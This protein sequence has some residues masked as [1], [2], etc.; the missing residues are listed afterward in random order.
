[1][2]DPSKSRRR[3]AGQASLAIA[4]AAAGLASVI[5]WSDRPV[6]GGAEI[7]RVAASAPLAGRIAA[8]ANDTA[9]SVIG[10]SATAGTRPT[11]RAKAEGPFVIGAAGDIACDPSNPLFNGG[12]GSPSHCRAA[13][14][15]RLLVRMRPDVVL[16]L[17]DTQY[18]DGRW[19]K[20]RESY[21]LS[22]GRLRG[23]TRPAV[24]NH[25][26]SASP[27]AWGYFSYFGERAGRIG[28]GWY[29]YNV[30]AWH[31]VALNSNCGIVGCDR[32]TRQFRW[33]KRDLASHPNACTLAY[34]HHPRYSSGPHGN[35][36]NVAPFW[37]VLYRRGADV[38]LNGHDHIYER[39]ALTRPNGRRDPKRGLR[40]FTIGTGG[41]Q[42]YSVESVKR[43]SQT[44]WDRSFGVLR[45]ELR[46]RT[47][48]W[49]FFTVGGSTFG[50]RGDGRCHGRP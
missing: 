3:R 10:R 33:L 15:K 31:L 8:P 5:A 39:F 40:Q 18:D 12:Q 25:E 17:G 11:V 23:R 37:R 49:R 24:G 45:M 46:P 30:G 42:L 13:D 7:R 6:G 19:W 50:D 16:A 36:R 27:R 14:T 44:H 43:N 2:K 29:S 48:V 4:V 20:Y 47:Y 1:V 21:A 28:H 22:W 35:D 38:I 9:L 26:Y 41:S 34:W 32:G